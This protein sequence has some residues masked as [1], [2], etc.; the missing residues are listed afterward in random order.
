MLGVDCKLPF[1]RGAIVGVFEARRPGTNEGVEDMARTGRD[2][3]R[4]GAGSD[5]ICTEVGR[6]RASDD[7]A[8]LG[9]EFDVWFAVTDV[10]L[11]GAVTDRLTL[12]P[13]GSGAGADVGVSEDWR[14]GMTM[15]P[16]PC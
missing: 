10:G 1:T 5:R 9:L 16:S 6:R 7:C 2:E 13:K 11:T 15:V 12:I 3:D 14:R 4:K 8:G